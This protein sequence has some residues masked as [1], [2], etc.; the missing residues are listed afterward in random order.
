MAR[1]AG[2]SRRSA[3]IPVR[4]NV[5]MVTEPGSQSDATSIWGSLRTGMSALRSGGASPRRTAGFPFFGDRISLKNLPEKIA[6]T[7][8]CHHADNHDVGH[9]LRG[10]Q[11][12]PAR[13]FS[14]HSHLHP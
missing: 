11:G 7:T 13:A 5:R 6:S 2:Y 1:V 9:V 14:H 12:G 4:S 3:D 8:G 10:N